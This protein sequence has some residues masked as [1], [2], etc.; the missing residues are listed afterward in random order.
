M[1]DILSA[2]DENKPP[3]SFHDIHLCQQKTSMNQNLKSVSTQAPFQAPVSQSSSWTSPPT[4]AN[5]S[6]VTTSSSQSFVTGNPLNF[7]HPLATNTFNYCSINLVP[8]SNPCDFNAVLKENQPTIPMT[9][10]DTVGR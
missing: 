2:G 4:T 3:Q 10:C 8:P 6:L 5:E 9:L 7:F 1:S